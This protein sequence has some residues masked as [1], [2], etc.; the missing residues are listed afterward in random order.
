MTKYYTRACN[1]YYG[2]NA[3]FLI[4]KKLA[5][6]LCG[7]KN[8]GFDKIEIITR[9]KKKVLS[10]IIH[11]NKIKNLNTSSKKKVRKDLKKIV[12]KR[13]NFLKNINFSEPSI[14]GILNLTPDSFSDGGR[15]NKKKKAQ[16]HIVEMIKGGAKIIDVGGE[17]TRPGSK[18]VPTKTEW[19]RIESV[20]KNF[21]KKH[22]I[23]R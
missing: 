10:N 3:K 2:T 23:T 6:P 11:I 13:E 5:L 18:T 14:M 1:F 17:S 8:I 21:K 20:I 22:K 7:N 15:F 16:K 9:K 19:K 4:K 12:L